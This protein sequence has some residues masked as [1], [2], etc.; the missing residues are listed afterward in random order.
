MKAKSIKGKSAGDI[1]I[2]LQQSMADGFEPTL[3]IVF[4]SA[5][6]EREGI[7]A[8]LSGKGIKIFGASTGNEFVDGEIE[9]DSVVILLLALDPECF[10]LHLEE[11][12]DSMRETVEVIGR[13]ALA[14][15]RKPAFLVVAGGIAVNGDEI[16][17]GIESACGEGTTLFG[18]F[19]AD[20]LEMKRSYVFS[21][22][23]LTEHGLL[24]LVVDDEKI[25]IKG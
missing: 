3:A 9:T 17:E 1:E 7:T 8:L 16:V 23:R 24:A 15:F 11:Q 6:K 12:G 13:S 22:D 18:G 10:Y 21:N 14:R 19:A 5:E 4:L 25:Q 2:A 20:K